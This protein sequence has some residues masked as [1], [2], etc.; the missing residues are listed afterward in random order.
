MK[1]SKPETSPHPQASAINNTVPRGP[2]SSTEDVG[3]GSSNAF[4]TFSNFLPPKAGRPT[5]KENG[6][7]KPKIEN[8][9]L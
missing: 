4:P 5:T 9:E 1:A 6:N 7:V 3:P 8:S 2:I